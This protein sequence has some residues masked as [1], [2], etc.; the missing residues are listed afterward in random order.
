M[1]IFFILTL[2]LCPLTYGEDMPEKDEPVWID[3]QM[4]EMV[5]PLKQW[6][7][8]TIRPDDPQPAPKQQQINLRQAIRLALRS[9]PGTVLSAGEKAN[10]YHIK[11]LSKQGVVKV[12]HLPLAHLPDNDPAQSNQSEEQP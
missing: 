9:Y 12:I 1:R 3:E 8:K 10:G 2:L 11:I 6:L 4:E 7:E 5:L